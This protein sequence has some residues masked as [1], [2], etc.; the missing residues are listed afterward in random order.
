MNLETAISEDSLESS[1]ASHQFTDKTDIPPDAL[2]TMKQVAQVLGVTEHCLISNRKNWKEILPRIQ[3]NG[4]LIRYRKS[5]VLKLIA[6]GHLL[7][8]GKPQE[9]KES[10]A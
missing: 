1:N 10:N 7:S 4:R 8:L 3:F 2:M 5:D 6:E 9:I